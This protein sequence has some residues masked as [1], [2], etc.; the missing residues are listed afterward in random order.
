MFIPGVDQVGGFSITSSPTHLR[1]TG[2][3][4]LAI[5]NSDSAPSNWV[6]TQVPLVN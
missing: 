4:Y 1:S 5:K 3:L 6:H 2:E